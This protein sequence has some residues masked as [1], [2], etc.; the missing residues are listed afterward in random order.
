MTISEKK[1]GYKAN[2]IKIQKITPT[3]AIGIHYTTKIKWLHLFDL[4]TNKNGIKGK[5]NTSYPEKAEVI[6][7]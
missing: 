2:S 6:L 7:E 5:N 3:K 1:I 4:A